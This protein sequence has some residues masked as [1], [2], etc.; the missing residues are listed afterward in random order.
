MFRNKVTLVSGDKNKVE[1]L[2]LS[3]DIFNVVLIGGHLLKNDLVLIAEH[4]RLFISP[5]T[6]VFDFS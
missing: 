4:I 5:D 3:L 1:W 2:F 6:S